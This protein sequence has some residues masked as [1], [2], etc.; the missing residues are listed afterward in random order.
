MSI[1][2]A[3]SSPSARFRARRRSRRARRVSRPSVPRRF[4][5][6]MVRDEGQVLVP[7]A[8]AHVGRPRSRKDCPVGSRRDRSPSPGD[9][10]PDGVP[11]DPHEPADGGLVHLGGRKPTRSPSR[12][13][14]ANRPGRRGRLLSARHD[15]AGQPPQLGTHLEAPDTEVEVRQRRLDRT[16]VIAC[17]RLEFA[18]GAAEQPPTQRPETTTA[19]S[20][21]STS[22][23]QMPGSARR[24]RMQRC[25]RTGNRPRSIGLVTTERTLRARHHRH[26]RPSTTAGWLVSCLGAPTQPACRGQVGPEGPSVGRS[27]A[28]GLDTDWSRLLLPPGAGSPSLP[29]AYAPRNALSDPHRCRKTQ[30]S[31]DIELLGTWLWDAGT[32]FDGRSAPEVEGLRPPVDLP[33]AAFGHL[34]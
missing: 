32:R 21:N 27:A 7:A 26:E 5:A 29:T 17:F 15:P 4:A 13:C 6:A 2:T 25:T 8:P 34:R 33:Q 24:Q 18:L 11:V 3:V 16:A 14:G 22:R 31:F 23:T 20:V 30:F 28:E 1:E 10:P 9:H 19:S 12:R